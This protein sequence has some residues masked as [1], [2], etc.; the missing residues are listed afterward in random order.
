MTPWLDLVE[1]ATGVSALSNCGGWPRV[2]ANGEL[3]ANGL[4]ADHARALEIQAAL[5]LACQGE[6]HAIC[7]V[8]A[9]FTE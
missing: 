7:D 5:P 4:I 3:S 1:A 6:H 9:V 8:W 2:F